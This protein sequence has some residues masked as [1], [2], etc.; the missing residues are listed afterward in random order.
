[1]NP[2]PATRP[3]IGEKPTIAPKIENATIEPTKAGTSASDSTSS[4]YGISTASTAPPSG[5]RK[6]APIPAPM[7]VL[8]AIRA[9]RAS[10]SRTRARNEPNPAPIWAVG[11]SRP[12]E[13][14]EPMVIADA[15]SLT[16]GIRA[17]IR[18]APWWK[19][20]IAASVPW[21]SASGANRNTMI[22]EMRPPSADDERDR[23]RPRR[24][25]DRPRPL[26]P[27]GDAGDEAREGPEEDADARLEG[28]EEERRADAADDADER[29]EDD[30]L[31]QVGGVRTRL[32]S[33]R[34]TPE[35]FTRTSRARGR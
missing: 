25:G 8:T 29:A 12:P 23:P 21:P 17:R 31:A 15:T 2:A 20:A 35:K 14:P 34:R 16:S 18:R 19:A 30:P 6:I 32:R 9:S 11:P 3:K 4:R 33:A 24:V 5:A 10:R 1:M 28:H 22:P 27:S 7:P 26:S 13:P